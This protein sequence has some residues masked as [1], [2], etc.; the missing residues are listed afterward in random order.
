MC[1]FRA[2][3]VIMSCMALLLLLLHNNPI[4][5]IDKHVNDIFDP[6]LA[7]PLTHTTNNHQH[8]TIARD[9]ASISPRY[10]IDIQECL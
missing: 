9:I 1:S 5:I 4:D 2:I 6:T 8:N 3:R 10:R 7:T